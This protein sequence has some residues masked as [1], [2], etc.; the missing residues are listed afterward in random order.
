[1]A[2]NVILLGGWCGFPILAC[3][4]VG[5]VGH[6][7]AAEPEKPPDTDRTRRYDARH[8]RSVR[9]ARAPLRDAGAERMQRWAPSYGRGS[10]N[11]RT[12]TMRRLRTDFATD[13]PL[14]PPAAEQEFYLNLDRTAGPCFA[15]QLL[16][17]VFPHGLL[18]I[19]RQ[20][21]IGPPCRSLTILN[22]FE[23]G[24]K[25]AERKAPDLSESLNIAE[26]S[27]R[28]QR[29]EQLRISEREIT[30][31]SYRVIRDMFRDDSIDA[32]V[33]RAFRHS[34]YRHGSPPVP[35]KHTTKFRQTAT[36]RGK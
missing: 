23:V 25:G 2:K 4:A 21:H 10:V 15:F 20:C 13:R 5:Y 7:Q 27:R 34:G 26:S 19:R 8:P 31:T 28:E 22:G 11:A 35:A 6:G 3:L 9:T 14:S 16:T 17:G 32:R 12:A 24:G 1:M 33:K 36:G 18:D 30:C 29:A